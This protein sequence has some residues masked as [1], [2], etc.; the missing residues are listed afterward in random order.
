MKPA[1]PHPGGAALGG[2]DHRLH[3]FQLLH[4][5]L[6][7]VPEVAALLT[8][9][10]VTGMRR[11][12]LVGLRRHRI[13]WTRRE[14]VVDAAID[15]GRR[16]KRTKTRKERTVSVDDDTLAMLQRHCDEMDARAALAE[17]VVAPNAFVFSNTIDASAP[18]P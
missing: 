4:G 14:I 16:I 9:G 2:N 3:A 7:V 1:Q 6:E 11:G 18:Q 17:A 12:E 8:L 5:A 13:L 10:A 15:A